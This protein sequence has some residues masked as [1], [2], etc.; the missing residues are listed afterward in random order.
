VVERYEI[1][2]RKEYAMAKRQ[3]AYEINQLTLTNDR[4]LKIGEVAKLMGV[5]IETLRFYERSGLL[6]VP[7][8]TEAGYRLYSTQTLTTLEF[9]KRAQMLG[10]SLVEIKRIKDESRA[11]TSPC[12]EVREIVRARLTEID[13]RLKQMRRYR[14]ALA[15]TLQQWEE[16]GHA[17]GHYCGLIESAEIAVALPSLPRLTKRK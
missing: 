2:N 8:R 17:D 7:V 12:S 5:S 15:Q 3:P 14:K 9:I 4:P 10:F 11:G 1:A 6:D 16:Q 13:E